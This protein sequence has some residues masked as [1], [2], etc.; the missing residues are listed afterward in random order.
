LVL[1]VPEDEVDATRK[2]VVETMQNAY[3]LRVPIVANAE[4]GKNWLEMEAIS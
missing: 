4:V 2:L 1:E 3:Q